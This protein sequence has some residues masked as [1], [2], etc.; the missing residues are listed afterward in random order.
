MEI[1]FSPMA[2]HPPNG[3]GH[4]HYRSFTITL[5][6]TTLGGTPLHELPA[7]RTDLHVTTHNTYKRHTSGIRTRSPSKR[8]DADP[9]LGPRGHRDRQL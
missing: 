5:R 2:Q 4:P 6:R 3:P 9:R 1:V 7:L 8:S